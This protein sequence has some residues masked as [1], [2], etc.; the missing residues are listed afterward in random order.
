M[1][2]PERI[3]KMASGRPEVSQLVADG[4][5]LDWGGE[6]TALETNG[7]ALGH[8][9]LHNG[10]ERLLISG[11]Q[12]L[13]TI[14]SN[15]SLTFRNVDMNPLGSYLSSLQRLRMLDPATLV[16]PSHGLPFVGLQ[17]RIDD[18]LRHHREK[19][20]RITTVCATPKRGV[21]I[22]PFMFR[23]KLE[24][25]HLFL[26]LGEALAHLEYLVHDHKLQRTTD[27]RGTVRYSVQ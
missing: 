24:G 27:A 7:H 19:L 11:D 1:F 25:A 9:C 23:R 4:D 16:L 2:S 17:Q 6:W 8:L 5:V 15:V 22:L 26:G 12:V 3:A 21:D 13:P 14:S 10:S 20:D 18:L